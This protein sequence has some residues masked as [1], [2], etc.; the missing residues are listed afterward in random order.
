MF[1]LSIHFKIINRWDFSKFR[2]TIFSLF[3]VRF[4]VVTAS[5]SNEVFTCNVHLGCR[6]LR[7]ALRS[8]SVSGLEVGPVVRVTSDRQQ[9]S[10]RVSLLKPTVDKSRA[11]NKSAYEQDA[12]DRPRGRLSFRIGDGQRTNGKEREREMAS[13][14]VFCHGRRRGGGGFVLGVQKKRGVQIS[15]LGLYVQVC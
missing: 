15:G 8:R 14:V 3:L 10:K 2:K 12:I 1:T 4:V 13:D 6:Q 9:C 11:Y 7:D 5:C